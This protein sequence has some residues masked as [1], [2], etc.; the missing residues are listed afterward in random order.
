MRSADGALPDDPDAAALLI[1][2]VLAA[3]PALWLARGTRQ[4]PLLLSVPLECGDSHVG[5]RLRLA[6][7]APNVEARLAHRRALL[8]M[9]AED[10]GDEDNVR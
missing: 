7:R 8:R 2:G 9:I 5:L 1:G 4:P 6:L 10:E 3:I